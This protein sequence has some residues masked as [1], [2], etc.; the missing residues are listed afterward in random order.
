MGLNRGTR[1]AANS[2]VSVTSRME[3]RG[4]KMYSFCAMYS[5]RMS[6][7]RVPERL[8]QSTPCCSAT[9]RYMAHNTEAGE[10]MVMETETSPS[11]IPRKRIS[12]SSSEEMG[13][14][15]L[16]TS[17][18]SEEHTSELQSLRHLVCRLLL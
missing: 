8:A 13:A 15:H 1:C 3:G 12:I 14:P 6:F 17:P 10:L 7:C 4:G 5:F 16:P 18:R 2:M 11:G 9:A